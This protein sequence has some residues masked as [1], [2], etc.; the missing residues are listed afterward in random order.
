M[1]PEPGCRSGSRRRRSTRAG[2]VAAAVAARALAGIARSSPG[3]ST[4]RASF[5]VRDE[6]FL[7]VVLLVL[8]RVDEL[9]AAV[10]TGERSIGVGHVSPPGAAGSASTAPG[11]ANRTRARPPG[12]AA[13]R[14]GGSGRQSA[15][16][17]V[18]VWDAPAGRQDTTQAGRGRMAVADRRA[19]RDLGRAGSQPRRVGTRGTCHNRRVGPGLPATRGRPER[20]D[21]AASRARIRGSGPILEVPGL[22]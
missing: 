11:R 7:R 18:P 14:L 8:G 6:P 4:A 21:P 10:D 15:V 5:G 1:A 16:L 12:G 3:G 17:K 9:G 22:S 19:G 20:R 2:P 13:G